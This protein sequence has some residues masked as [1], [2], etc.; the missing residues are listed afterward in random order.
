M[1]KA[2]D[3]G[4]AGGRVVRRGMC[5]AAD[6]THSAHRRRCSRHPSV[7]K[8]S[9]QPVPLGFAY[10]FM[11]SRSL[12][13]EPLLTQ[14]YSCSLTS[15]GCLLCHSSLLD[16][17]PITNSSRGVFL[18]LVGGDHIYFAASRINSLSLR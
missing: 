11:P 3:D 14:N 15:V 5:A 18:N 12:S 1:F 6:M 17:S 13:I 8:H 16:L 7:A 10:K 2:I 4:M 9:M